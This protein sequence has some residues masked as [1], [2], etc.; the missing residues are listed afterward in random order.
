MIAGSDGHWRR[1]STPDY[2]G[3]DPPDIY[4]QKLRNINEMARSLGVAGFNALVRSNVMR[5]K[6]TGRFAPVPA[7]DPY[8]AG[9]PP[10]N[11][12]DTLRV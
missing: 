6:M 9:N 7:N 5:N 3:Q 12:P 10:I 11:T 4:Y 2:D 8:T 1:I